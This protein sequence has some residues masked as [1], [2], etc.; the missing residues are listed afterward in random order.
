MSVAQ[1]TGWSVRT[2]RAESS[3]LAWAFTISLTLHL[4]VAGAYYEGKKLG[5]WQYAHWPAWMQSVKMLSALLKKKN[6]EQPP[7]PQELPL[8]FVQV[9]P[10]Q[11]VTEPPKEAKYYSDKNSRAA[12]PDAVVETD[13][14]KISGKQTQVVKTEDI[15]RENF[16]PLQPSVAVQPAKKAEEEMRA[17]PAQTP[18]DL[19]MGKPEPTP[20]K[21]DGKDEHS[22]PRTVE[23]ALARLNRSRLP[24]E[25]MKQEGGVK[26]RLEIASLDARATP[27][28]EYDNALVDAISVRWWRLLEDRIYASDARGKVILQFHLHPDGRITEMNV[29]GSTTTEEIWSL[30]CQKA[31]LDNAPFP[32]WPSDMRRSMP[33]DVRSMQFTFYYN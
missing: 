12:N 1:M 33:G 26:R 30:I 13:T 23:Q 18:G 28:G 11:A 14:P 10:A 29:A 15:P 17:K 6:T 3:R 8:I 25:K 21:E 4:L 2:E 5:W 9:S 7:Q 19:A 27:F 22:R 31:V 32:P 24:S 16:I 20:K